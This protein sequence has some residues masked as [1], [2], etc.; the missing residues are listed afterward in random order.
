M[1]DKWE[2][3]I[4]SRFT[5]TLWALSLLKL[6]L[7]F[8]IQLF[9]VMLTHNFYICLGKADEW[10]NF[11]NLHLSSISGTRDVYFET[12]FLLFLTYSSKKRSSTR[13]DNNNKTFITRIFAQNDKRTFFLWIKAIASTH[14]MILIHETLN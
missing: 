5:H 4:V 12:C 8:K 11:S 2:S 6:E 9:S 3:R 10:K 13:K 7:F 1:N 14:R